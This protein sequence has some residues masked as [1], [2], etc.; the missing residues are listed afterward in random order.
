MY[1]FKPFIFFTS[2]STRNKS[3]MFQ[4]FITQEEDIE[5]IM[6]K[7]RDIQN[8]RFLQLAFRQNPKPS[9]DEKKA[10]ADDLDMKYD[11]VN[12]WFQ[13]ER[14]RR[15][16]FMSVILFR[17]ITIF[18]SENT[19]DI[20]RNSHKRVLISRNIHDPAG[21]TH[22]QDDLDDSSNQNGQ[23]DRAWSYNEKDASIDIYHK[24]GTFVEKK[25]AQ[26]RHSL[27]QKN[28]DLT[29]RTFIEQY[30]QNTT[31]TLIVSDAIQ[32]DDV[33][34]GRSFKD[35]KSAST[36]STHHRS[37]SIFNSQNDGQA[38]NTPGERSR[39][40]ID[41]VGQA[42]PQPYFQHIFSKRS[43]TQP[44]K[45]FPPAPIHLFEEQRDQGRPCVYHELEK[46]G[47]VTKHQKP[48][49]KTSQIFPTCNNLFIPMKKIRSDGN[50]TST[51]YNSGDTILVKGKPYRFR[52]VTFLHPYLWGDDFT[53]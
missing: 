4:R 18:S 8:Y 44:F 38:R 3:S 20:Q 27:F 31:R 49:Y 28:E 48:S 46:P 50:Y 26:S 29:K 19:V 30:R 33:F 32:S 52:N 35:N 6:N 22:K 51:L 47:T 34:N 15:R 10:L 41:C 17:K 23:A 40:K 2:I 16:K 13:N 7:K 12:I 1:D 21:Y 25:V 36:G 24:K 45:R 14:A 39:F 37:M 11:K 53:R 42:T 9:Y 43:I 5:I